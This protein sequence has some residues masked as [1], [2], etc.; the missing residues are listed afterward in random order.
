M[1]PNGVKYDA[2]GK[3]AYPGTYLAAIIILGVGLALGI[4]AIIQNV[5]STNEAAQILGDSDPLIGQLRMLMFVSIITFVVNI[6][7]FI[8]LVTGQKWGRI[9]YTAVFVI[10][11]IFVFVVVAGMPQGGQI[12]GGMIPSLILPILV[13]IF[14]WLP[15]ATA[16]LNAMTEWRARQQV[17]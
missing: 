5:Q 4:F 3:P 1:G 17:R 8:G 9:L 13:I 11:I 15:N 6:G 10:N 2:S 12:I 16:Y 14:M 7:S